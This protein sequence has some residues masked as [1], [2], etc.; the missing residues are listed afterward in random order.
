[1]SRFQKLW[2]YLRL[3]RRQ[4]KNNKHDIYIFK[5]PPRGRFF[6]LQFINRNSSLIT[7]CHVLRY[8]FIHRHKAP[9]IFY[10]MKYITLLLS[11]VFWAQTYSQEFQRLPLTPGAV[12]AD[13]NYNSAQKDLDNQDESLSIDK[14]G[15]VLGQDLPSGSSSNIYVEGRLGMSYGRHLWLLSYGLSNPWDFNLGG[16][17]NQGNV[18]LLSGSYG[19]DLSLFDGINTEVYLGLSYI[20]QKTQNA[21]NKYLG[22]PLTLVVSKTIVQSCSLGLIG[23]LQ[24]TTKQARALFG[25]SLNYTMN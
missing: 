6:L 22:L 21:S 7:K 8:R 3:Q 20:S 16:A 18:T 2:I 9:L 13:Q 24:P 5:R 15:L 19:Q 17:P 23:Q 12:A 4:N 25:L 11:L 1:M 14:I 10:I